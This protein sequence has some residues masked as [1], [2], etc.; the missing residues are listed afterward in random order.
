[1]INQLIDIIGREARLFESFLN[2]LEQQKRSLVANDLDELN[3]ITHLQQEAIT[4]SYRLN[5]ERERLVARIAADKS[6]QGDVNIARLIELADADQA[7]RLNE[8]RELIL[9][10][11][12]KILEVRNTNAL[13]ISQSREMIARTM[14]MLSRPEYADST[15]A[16]DARPS[17]QAD[18]VALDRRI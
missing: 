16:R 8:L 10:L 12:D 6:L 14:K 11:N 13:L 3:R 9:S 2:L 15:Y 4:E 5:G 18:A 1:M 17:G 7:L